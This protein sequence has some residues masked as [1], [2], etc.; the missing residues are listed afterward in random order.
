MRRGPL[1]QRDQLVDLVGAGAVPAGELPEPPPLAAVL[2]HE[3]VQVHAAQ[4]TA[5]PH[6]PG[7]A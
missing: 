2:G 6:A 1:V 3:R 7:R 4:H 5:P